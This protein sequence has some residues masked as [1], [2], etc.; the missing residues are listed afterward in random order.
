MNKKNIKRITLFLIILFVVT[1]SEDE[2]TERKFPGIKTLEVTNISNSGAKFN[3]E[4]VRP[5]NGEIVEYGFVW[6]LESNPLID[7]SNKIV[8]TG[9]IIT[10]V[11]SAQISTT[12]REGRGYYTRAYAKTNDYIVYG[13]TYSFISL[14]SEA[15]IIDD[16][17]PRQGT[18]GDTITL[19]GKNFSYIKNQNHVL[20]KDKVSIVTSSTDSTITCIVPDNILDNS[21]INLSIANQITQ[22]RNDFELSE[23]EIESFSPLKGT[24]A[25]TVKLIGKNFSATT[26]R[27]IVS[28][29][30]HQ[31][32]VVASSKTSLSVVVPNSINAQLNKV[33]ITLGLKS[34]SAKDMFE[35]LAPKIDGI[36]P[37]SGSSNTLI[38]I[39]GNNFNPNKVG[40]SIYFDDNFGE[41]IEASKNA[42]TVKIPFGA[43]TNRSFKVRVTVAGQT[44]YNNSMFTIEDPWLKRNDVPAVGTD[45]YHATAF[46]ILNKGYVGLGAQSNPILLYND[47]H[48]YDPIQNKWTQISNFPGTGILD[49]TSFV[50]GNFAYVGTGRNLTDATS[51][52]WKYNP[53]SDVWTQ[54][55]SFPIPISHAK[56]ISLNG[57]GYIITDNYV[58]NFWSYDP[59]IDKWSKMPDIDMS[60]VGGGDSSTIKA[61]VI[62]SKIYVCITRNK[63]YTHLFEFDTNNQKWTKKDG[64][65]YGGPYGNLTGGGFSIKDKGYIIGSTKLFQYNPLSDSWIGLSNFPID[66]KYYPIAFEL[67]GKAY[68]G[69][70]RYEPGFWEY[71][72]EYE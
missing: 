15:A 16:F 35:I 29:N 58:D 51:E 55:E 23:P 43:Y 14:G 25:D 24:F 4:I 45:R 39:T 46:S 50:I 12:L 33:D 8:Y 63:Y 64:L 21:I 53:A 59:S 41:V 9:E 40:D 62:E 3:A 5:G 57:K 2:L 1:C 56:G 13:A 30:G 67:D 36:S 61:F 18:W 68:Y 32:E 38:K 69:T 7:L 31:G 37:E 65:F 20:F 48:Q 22:S 34:D 52:F 17:I 54:I 27:N 6:G 70:G 44:T 11:F 49:A 10:G 42:L 71:S 19:V 28:F 60:N 26:N 72:P 66:Y 47:F